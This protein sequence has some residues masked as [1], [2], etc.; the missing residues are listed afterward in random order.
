[1]LWILDSTQRL[2]SA[3]VFIRNH[4]LRPE[5][6]GHIAECPSSKNPGRLRTTACFEQLRR[7]L[8]HKLAPLKRPYITGVEVKP[9]SVRTLR[10]EPRMP[11]SLDPGGIV[12]FYRMNFRQ[13]F[14]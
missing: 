13:F 12:S 3:T 8:L 7:G 14:W 6:G 2:N 10:R 11:V 1:M 4:R 5:T 9:F